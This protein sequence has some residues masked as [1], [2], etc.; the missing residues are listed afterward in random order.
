MLGGAACAQVN[1]TDNQCRMDLTSAFNNLRV[2]DQNN[3][4]SYSYG[5]RLD[6]TEKLGT[7][8]TTYVGWLKL[9]DDSNPTQELLRSELTVY[10]GSNLIQ[11]TVADGKRVWS[12]DPIQNAYSADAYN[13]E[14]GPNAPNYRS[15]F[16]S[17]FKQT[18]SGTPNHLMTLM[19]QASITGT[20]RV[21]DWLGGIAFKGL[22]TVDA[23][24][25]AHL[26]EQIWQSVPDNSRF[27]Q[28]NLESNDT[29]SSWTLN[30]IQIH[31]VESLR[32][33]SKVTDTYLTQAKDNNNVAYSYPASDAAFTFVPPARSRVLASPRTVKF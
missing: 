10:L 18:A 13:V 12:Y 30:S 14:S 11:R 26:T 27:V 25:P 17:L 7:K 5:L 3:L 22:Q 6:T 4:T 9:Y 1:I 15:N 28:F 19:D 8:T 24:D 2:I 31:R 16:V 21:K 32:G 33:L 20:A 23:N 29:G